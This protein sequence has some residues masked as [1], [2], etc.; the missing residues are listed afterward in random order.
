MAATIAQLCRVFG[1]LGMKPMDPDPYQIK[2]M[3]PNIALTTDF[4]F[5][6]FFS[7]SSGA[8]LVLIHGAD[9]LNVEIFC[10]TSLFHLLQGYDASILLNSTK[11]NRA[12]K[13]QDLKLIVVGF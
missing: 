13:H 3:H 12:E 6:L 8:Q 9:L 4:F 1:P 11:D 2:K 7:D 10:D 5:F